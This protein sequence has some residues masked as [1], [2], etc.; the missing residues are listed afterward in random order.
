[1]TRPILRGEVFAEIS[2]HMQDSQQR[3]GDFT[4]THEALGVALEEWEELKSAVR[5]NALEST[6]EEAIDLAAVLIRLAH[7]CRSNQK[8]CKRSVK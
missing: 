3:Y 5:A 1:M 7:Q 2:A 6:R 8:L 4:S